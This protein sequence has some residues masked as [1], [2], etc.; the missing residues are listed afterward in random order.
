MVKNFLNEEQSN[1]IDYFIE[2]KSISDIAKILNKARSTI[3]KWLELDQVKTEIE[4]RKLEIKTQARS[5]I[6]SKVGGCIE[7]IIE[8]AHTSKDLRTKLAANKYICDQFL[9][10]PGT[11][12]EEKEEI[13]TKNEIVDIDS[14]I[15]EINMLKNMKA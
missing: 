14:L 12:K 5:K 13:D 2:G 1:M 15:D 8:I 11:A 9:G 4:K 7:N 3:Y 6:A 10:V